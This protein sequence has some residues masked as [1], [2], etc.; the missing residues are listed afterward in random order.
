M[1]VLVICMSVSVCRCVL[2]H[3]QLRGKWTSLE[4]DIVSFVGLTRTVYVHRIDRMYGKSPAKF[5]VYTPYIRMYVWFW[6]TLSICH[7]QAHARAEG[8]R[9][10]HLGF[11]RRIDMRNFVQVQLLWQGCLNAEGLCTWFITSYKCIA[12]S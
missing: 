9:A 5:I 4:G 6:P 2:V 8:G 12:R 10:T 3:V 7:W 1:R 11:A